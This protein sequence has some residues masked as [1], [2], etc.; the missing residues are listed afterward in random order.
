VKSI[1]GFLVAA[2]LATMTLTVFL[3]ALHGYRSSMVEVQ[4]L[5]DTE[6]TGHARLLSA[7]VNGRT[8]HETVAGS[9]GQRAFQV[10]RDGALLWRSDNAPDT[11]ITNRAGFQDLNFGNHRWR[12]YTWAGENGRVLATAAERIDVRNALAE[13]IIIESVL[14]VIMALPLAGLLIWLIVGYGL[15]PLRQL[16]KQ[17]RR[18]RADDLGPIPTGRQPVEL[19]QLVNST[20][21]LLHRLEASFERERRFASDA[22]HELRTP[23]A[24]LKVHLHNITCM[25]PDGNPELASL[26]AAVDRMGLSVEQILALYR[27]SPDHYFAQ[28]ARLDL[29]QLARESIAAMYPAFERRNIQLELTGSTAFIPGDRPALETLI[30]NL[31]DNACKYTPPGGRVHVTVSDQPQ[32]VTL[33][34]EDSG[35]GI[36][37]DQYQRIFDRFYRLGGDQHESG[38]IGCGLGLAIVQHIADLHGASIAVGK[39]SFESGL[40]MTITFPRHLKRRSDSAGR[41]NA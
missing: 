13:N 15:S 40:A 19:M 17:L 39:S 20:N 27:T 3:A 33:R 21:G 18:R 25:L 10:F 36:P 34:T 22:A 35:P 32:G 1:R 29:Q 9:N 26:V 23:I 41:S 4:A 28:L 14:P 16:A 7:S 6:L 38:I 31:L 24:A 2:L 12:T 11:P 5:L 8:H 30:K 37:E